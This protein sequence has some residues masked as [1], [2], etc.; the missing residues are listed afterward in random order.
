V[1]KKLGLTLRE[2]HRLR[3]F[4]NTVLRGI[5]GPGRGEGTGGWRRLYNEKLHNLYSLSNI[6][7]AIKLKM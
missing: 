4:E 3:V 5:F 1:D 6:M 7:R 2:G